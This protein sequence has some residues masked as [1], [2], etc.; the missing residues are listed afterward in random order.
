MIQNINIQEFFKFYQIKNYCRD[1]D[2][3][4]L[5]FLYYNL[6]FCKYY[7]LF[8]DISDYMYTYKINVNN[9][10]YML[11]FRKDSKSY[12]NEKEKIFNES[13]RYNDTIIIGNKKFHYF[14]KNIK[15]PCKNKYFIDDKTDEITKF[16][17]TPKK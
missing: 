1:I 4:L 2:I 11:H 14:I 17:E 7:P 9:S 15:L 3:C 5:K 8:S 6:Y 13:I 10:F 12:E 16:F